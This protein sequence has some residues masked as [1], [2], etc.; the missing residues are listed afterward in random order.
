[1]AQALGEERITALL[2]DMGETI[3]NELSRILVDAGYRGH[4]AP[5]S[6]KFRIFTSG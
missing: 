6:H 5:E 2:Q 4:N 1:L 3:G